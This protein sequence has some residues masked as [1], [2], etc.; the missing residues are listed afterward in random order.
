M[1]KLEKL[2]KV[3]LRILIGYTKNKLRQK[4][5][6]GID[7]SRDTREYKH[8]KHLG[9]IHFM[10]MFDEFEH[11]PK[12]PYMGLPDAIA[13]TREL[14]EDYEAN[15]SLS[16]LATIVQYVQ[17][18]GADFPEGLEGVVEFF[19]EY[20]GELEWTASQLKLATT[21]SKK[22]HLL[23]SLLYK[24]IPNKGLFATP[25]T[26][27]ELVQQALNFDIL[28]GTK[29]LVIYN[30]Y[31]TGDKPVDDFDKLEQEMVRLY[32][33]RTTVEGKNLLGKTIKTKAQLFTDMTRFSRDR[34]VNSKAKELREKS[35]DII[36]LAY[37]T[38]VVA[39]RNTTILA[40][41]TK[42]FFG[43]LRETDLE[44]SKKIQ[45]D[46]LFQK[47]RIYES[48]GYTLVL[49]GRFV[50]VDNIRS[51]VIINKTPTDMAKKDIEMMVMLLTR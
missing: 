4:V 16:G 19:K 23:S 17:E 22:T 28:Q 3:A 49:R 43:V 30:L 33:Y 27:D 14:L 37:L 26:L 1:V 34:V 29:G 51:Q 32:F 10:D 39:F 36:Y 38:Q 24:H 41:K 42:T 46:N 20:L 5:V 9:V 6:G 7:M 50:L 18:R 12:I 21:G 8:L 44:L 48:D 35:M 45:T 15:K 11:L 25:I 47:T 13:Y 40:S 31:N 2:L